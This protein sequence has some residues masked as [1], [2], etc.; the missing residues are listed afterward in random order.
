MF[1]VGSAEQ[2]ATKPDKQRGEDRS[3]THWEE[4]NK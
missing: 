2:K 4:L 1:N 3:I